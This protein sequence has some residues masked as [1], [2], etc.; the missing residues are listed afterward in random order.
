LKTT[1]INTRVSIYDT[2][3]GGEGAVKKKEL[4]LIAPI[5]KAPSTDKDLRD[6]I[7]KL[8]QEASV[9][10]VLREISKWEKIAVVKDREQERTSKSGRLVVICR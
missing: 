1:W 8:P 3:L 4:R 9:S 6:R 7:S 10:S 5:G 2:P